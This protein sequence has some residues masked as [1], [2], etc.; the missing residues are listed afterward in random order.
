MAACSHLAKF[1]F[2]REKIEIGEG[3][4]IR[5]LRI[6]RVSIRDVRR[7]LPLGRMLLNPFCKQA[8]ADMRNPTRLDLVT[9]IDDDKTGRM[10]EKRTHVG[11]EHGVLNQVVDNIEGKCETERAEI[12]WYRGCEIEAFSGISSEALLTNCDRPRCHIDTDIAGVVR[13]GE[14]G[15]ITTAKF[16]D[17][18]NAVAFDEIIQNFGLEFCETAVGADTGGAAL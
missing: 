13:K 2:E 1:S 10:R 6:I 12:L 7:L 17:R 4:V 11:I 3:G 9:R 8:M 14:L 5:S 15:T 18:L 16:D